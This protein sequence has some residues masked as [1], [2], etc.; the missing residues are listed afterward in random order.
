MLLLRGEGPLL[1]SSGGPKAT[2]SD[3]FASALLFDSPTTPSAPSCTGASDFASD[4]GEDVDVVVVDEEEEEEVGEE[5]D[6]RVDVVVVVVV[7]V[8]VETVLVV[9]V[10]VAAMKVVGLT[11]S[12]AFMRPA[13]AWHNVSSSHDKTLQ[14]DPNSHRKVR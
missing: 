1:L 10:M 8:V 4:D 11:S 3:Q 14:N 7:E 6:S 13:T 12:S 2:P 9:V 5:D